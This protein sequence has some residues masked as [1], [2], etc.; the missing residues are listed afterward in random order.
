MSQ[1]F[2]LPGA[3]TDGRGT[4]SA[5]PKRRPTAQIDDALSL[6][7]NQSDNIARC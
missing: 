5:P 3:V 2:G 1:P 4:R 6:S 7:A